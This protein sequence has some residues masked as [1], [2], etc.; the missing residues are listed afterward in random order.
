MPCDKHQ[1]HARK[2]VSHHGS[3]LYMCD[4]CDAFETKDEAQEPCP[5]RDRVLAA[6]AAEAELDERLEYE[7]MKKERERWAYLSAK[8]QKPEQT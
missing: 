3:T 6:R 7:R 8:Y 2:D 4:F 1:S 5:A